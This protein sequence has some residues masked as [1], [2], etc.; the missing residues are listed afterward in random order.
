VD[1]GLNDEVL[2]YQEPSTNEIILGFYSRP[3]LEGIIKDRFVL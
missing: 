3:M 1:D 2:K